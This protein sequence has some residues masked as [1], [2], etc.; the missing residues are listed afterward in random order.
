[1]KSNRTGF[2]EDLRKCSSGFGTS[3]C[4]LDSM[5]YGIQIS[6]MELRRSRF[7]QS[8]KPGT[9]PGLFLEKVL[10]AN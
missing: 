4:R 7:D 10:P 9:N 2:R 1:L 3:A 5:Y 6:D 8:K